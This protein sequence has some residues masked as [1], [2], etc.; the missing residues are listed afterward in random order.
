VGHHRVGTEV[1]AVYEWFHDT[2]GFIP[3]FG[4]PVSNGYN[5]M[6]AGIIVAIMIIPIVTSITREVF[7]TVPL[8]DKQAAWR[9][10]PPVGNDQGCGLPAQL[11]R[12][13]RCRECSASAARWARRSRSRSSSAPR[14]R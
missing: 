12:H 4:V 1:G 9:S 5:Y 7:G 11:R 2:L 14:S 6:T 13:G 3:L 8:L 10:A